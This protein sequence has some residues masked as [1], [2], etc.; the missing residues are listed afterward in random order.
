MQRRLDAAPKPDTPSGIVSDRQSSRSDFLRR[1]YLPLPHSSWVRRAELGSAYMA[2]QSE[3]ARFQILLILCAYA[4]SPAIV[5]MPTA[6]Q[7]APS[8]WHIARSRRS[9]R[10]HARTYAGV[11]AQPHPP[12]APP[13]TQGA[14]LSNQPCYGVVN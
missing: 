7:E 2:C 10:L 9:A 5:P 12:R 3:S 6:H 1:N 8:S 13:H 14:R 11:H 4:A